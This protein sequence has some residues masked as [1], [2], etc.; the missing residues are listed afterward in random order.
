MIEEHL[1]S[2]DVVQEQESVSEWPDEDL[3]FD[4]D[5]FEEESKTTSATPSSSK[6]SSSTT[7]RPSFTTA[8]SS[9]LHELPSNQASRSSET[10]GNQND[11]IKDEEEVRPKGPRCQ[12]SPRD[13]RR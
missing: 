3:N 4:F 6:S 5:D 8:A 2:A 7:P 11:A 12:Y 10:L 13:S 9:S 1:P